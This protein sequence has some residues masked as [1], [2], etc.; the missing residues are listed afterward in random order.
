MSERNSRSPKERLNT[1]RDRI[2]SA[3][4]RLLV[5]IDQAP[6][7]NPFKLEEYPVNVDGFYEAYIEARYKLLGDARQRDIDLIRNTGS[8]AALSMHALTDAV[9]D[10]ARHGLYYDSGFT[11]PEVQAQRQGN[12]AEFID[13][14]SVTLNA[15]TRDTALELTQ[16][17]IVHANKQ[18]PDEYPDRIMWDSFQHMGCSLTVDCL[19]AGIS[20]E[21]LGVQQTSEIMG[22]S[23]AIVFTYLE[24]DP[25]MFP[26]SSIVEDVTYAFQQRVI[27]W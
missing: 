15:E 9:Y 24:M 21:D 16:A 4:G 26:D 10:R 20:F 12:S 17:W 3:L 14:S 2:R 8:A 27:N 1:A 18:Q 5:P 25:H 23:P 11:Y 7:Q 22:K 19:P 6:I 13:A